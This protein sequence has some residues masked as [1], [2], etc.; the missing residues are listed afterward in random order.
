MIVVAISHR[1]RQQRRATA[2][3]LKKQVEHT[4]VAQV[5]AHFIALSD[6][7][8]DADPATLEVLGLADHADHALLGYVTD[9]A[10]G[11]EKVDLIGYRNVTPQFERAQIEMLAQI[12]RAG[13]TDPIEHY[14]ISWGEN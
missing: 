6:Y 13:G 11:G 4:T 7:L 5:R 8:R 9:Q 12:T 2:R 10:H 1:N 3:A 14:V